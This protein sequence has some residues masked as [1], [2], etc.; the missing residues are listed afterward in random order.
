MRFVDYS[1]DSRASTPL[2]VMNGFPGA[3]KTTIIRHLLE[4]SAQCRIVAIVR[5]VEP[6]LAAGPTSAHRRGSGVEWENGCRAI[7]SDDATATLATLS[8]EA[9]KP[10]HVI[11]ETSGSRNPR[12]AGGYAYMP[13]YR[14]SGM[15]TVVDA[16]TAAT[17]ESEESFTTTIQP[18][19]QSADLVVLTKLDVAGQEATALAQRSISSWTPSTRFIWCRSGRIA[20]PLLVGISSNEVLPD[21]PRVVA[22]W[23]ADYIPVKSE[24]KT[25]MGERCRSWCLVS[26][27]RADARQFRGWVG[28][29][30]TSIMRGDGVVFLREE[31]QHRHE[32][33][34]LGSRWT[35]ER[36]AP[37]GNETPA[38]RIT[39]VGVEARRSE[40]EQRPIDSAKQRTRRDRPSHAAL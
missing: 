7:E 37:W 14:P 25:M 32:F 22:E 4:N 35:L 31:P 34:L 38:T 3:G 33:R 20:P 28:R 15:L 36:G 2:T 1:G 21:D 9:T 23:R 19:V 11:V 18:L 6:L 12:R 5:D 30:P 10:D 16:T 40:T 26:T 13:G 24:R 8:R 17:L 39:L 27:D 29:L